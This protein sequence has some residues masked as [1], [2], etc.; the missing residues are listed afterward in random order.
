MAPFPLGD[1]AAPPISMP[2]DSEAVPPGPNAS[3]FGAGVAS[4]GLLGLSRP[5]G[6]ESGSSDGFV[7]GVA[8]PPA[9]CGVGL[10]VVTDS[11][12]SD[13][14]LKVL[15]STGVVSSG[16]GGQ[17]PPVRTKNFPS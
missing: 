8:R 11:G 7:S 13:F 10:R 6:G 4:A 14:S 15:G 2:P 17:E 1:P 16:A 12:R 3:L 9:F 5:E